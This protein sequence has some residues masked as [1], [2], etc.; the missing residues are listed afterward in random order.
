[1]DMMI[2]LTGRQFGS[3]RLVRRLAVGGFASVYL[4]QH[5]RISS[6]Q[7]AIKILHLFDVDVRQFRREAETTEQLTHPNIV[8]LL[9]FD[10]QEGTPFLVLDYAPGGSLRMRHPKGSQVP[11]ATVIE[12]LKELASA[13]QYAHD[14]NTLHR[15]I[16]PDNIL[17][18]RQEELL[19]SDFGM[20][21]L[22]QTGKTSIDGPA[23]TGGTPYYMAPEQFRG[24]PE[25]ASDQYALA[26]VVYEW[27]TG[28]TPFSGGDFIQLGFQHT[29]ETVPPL[30][31]FVSAVPATV[32]QVVLKALSKQPQERFPRVADFAFALQSAMQQ[33]TVPSQA[34]FSSFQS[35]ASAEVVS[36][37]PPLVPV[38]ISHPVQHR[39]VSNR[40][41]LFTLLLVLLVVLIGGSFS[42][43]VFNTQKPNNPSDQGI[44]ATATA[45]TQAT[46]TAAAQAIATAQPTVTKLVVGALHVGSIHDLGYNQAM[47]EG[48]EEMKKSVS[49]VKVIE[50][51][52]VPESADAERVM[53]NMISQGAKLIFAQSFG[54]LEP[55]LNV[56]KRH[57]DVVFEHAAGNKLAA[58]LGTFWS[59]TIAYE[60]LM[61]VV[62]GKSTKTNKLGWVIGYPVPNIL[63]SI[64][65]FE[66][67]AKSVNPK[68]TTQVI[69]DNAWVDPAKEA[70]A[71]NALAGNG[72]DVVT[73]IVDSPSTVV[74]TA[75]QR[76]IMSI[77]FHC[78]CVQSVAGNGWLTGI[79]FTWGPLFT[80]FAND[81]IAGKWKSAN[82]V[83]SLK[84]GYNAIAPYGP[85]VSDEAKQLVEQGKADLTSGKRQIFKGP[86]MDNQGQVRI[87][88]GEVGNVDDLLTSTDWLV[89]GA[90][91]QII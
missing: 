78:L 81:V 74:Q 64:N 49:G 72:I 68:A 52:N 38:A 31:T 90:T 30:Q 44:A 88:E 7:A 58:N 32:E 85:S 6:K 27:L 16:K 13:L 73:M 84:E 46:A 57:P 4:G 48:L 15:D 18:G 12:Y 80:Q 66:L 23:N 47:H 53:E 77:G 36:Y 61:G 5:V 19:L 86:I 70:E 65:A 62:A 39:K 45:A 41:L 91:G 2:D 34:P 89:E 51:E 56:A 69:A 43:F 79:G 25:K 87:K 24:K 63:T 50:E 29:Y 59:D 67:G 76:K 82:I 17:I 10:I 35:P 40:P 9:D 71:V 42:Y 55:V 26:T 1:M 28:T 3:Y 60:Y 20:A 54:Y 75:A 22:S 83:G 33:D 8:R 11:L 21:L 37:P 14:Q